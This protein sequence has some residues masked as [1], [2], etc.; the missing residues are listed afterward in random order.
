MRRP[1]PE[2]GVIMAGSRGD[3]AGSEGDASQTANLAAGVTMVIFVRE[4]LSDRLFLV[5]A[6]RDQDR[7]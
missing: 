6:Q 3:P 1:H 7:S 5:W 4:Y 2:T